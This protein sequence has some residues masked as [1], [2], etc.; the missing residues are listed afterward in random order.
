MSITNLDGGM[1]AAKV[2]SAATELAE[3]IEGKATLWNDCHG[4][5]TGDYERQFTLTIEADAAQKI[6]LAAQ[7]NALVFLAEQQVS[8]G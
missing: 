2:Q 3:W 1:A 8:R 7:L 4:S 6:A 5:V